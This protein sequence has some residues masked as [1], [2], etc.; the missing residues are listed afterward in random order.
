MSELV[1]KM[2]FCPVCYVLTTCLQAKSRSF[3]CYLRH[4]LS[5]KLFLS[6]QIFQRCHLFSQKYSDLFRSSV[7]FIFSFI[8]SLYSIR[9]RLS[10]FILLLGWSQKGH[11]Q[12]PL[13][14]PTN[15]FTQLVTLVDFHSY[16]TIHTVKGNFVWLA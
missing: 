3:W 6:S 11:L 12:F 15:L 2:S 16:G 13:V 8:S 14:F 5:P 9:N 7:F 10:L 1:A 4:P